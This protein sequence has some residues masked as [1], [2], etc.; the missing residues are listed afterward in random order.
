MSIA[1]Q[2]AVIIGCGFAG[3]ALALFLKRAGMKCEIYEAR[4]ASDLD[5][6]AF[7][8]LAPNGMNVLKDLG[9]EP[10]LE[11]DGFPTTGITFYNSRGKTIGELDN[12]FDKERYGVR[13]HVLK[14]EYIFKVFRDE[15]QRQGIPIHFGKR[16][17]RVSQTATGVEATF[18]D[19]TTASGDLLIGS[20][21]KVLSWLEIH[22][23]G[24][25]PLL[26]SFMPQ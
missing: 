26:N 4:K 11:Q 3:T 8:Y 23:L 20:D 2:K 17:K 16:L 22:S 24:Q 25:Q 18:K 12:R 21:N 15:V 1:K 7:L 6:G 10:L 5:A 9:L 19:D 14:R 13:G